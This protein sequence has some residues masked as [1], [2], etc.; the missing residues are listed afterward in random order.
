MTP[1]GHPV[2]AAIIVAAGSSERFG[3][4]NKLLVDLCGEPVVARAMRAIATELR[5]H[6]FVIVAAAT[7]IQAM[8]ETVPATVGGRPIVFCSGGRTRGESV[9]NGLDALSEA[10]THVAVHDGARPLPTAM[11][12]R[13]VL[14]TAE[15]DGAAIPALPPSST[16][17]VRSTHGAHMA[18]VLDR[19]RL[20]ELQTPQA[21]RLRDLRDA[22]SRF[23]DET[24]ESTALFRAGY[25]VSVVAGSRDNIKITVPED[26]VIARAL[27][28]AREASE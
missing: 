21:A 5:I 25:G 7:S 16:I 18:G 12:V 11:L 6:E 19:S 2:W 3:S 20:Y 27:A 15:R 8:R 1:D 24:D 26:I 9:R 10:V 23:P 4:E 13:E 14:D 22:L 28:G 17:A